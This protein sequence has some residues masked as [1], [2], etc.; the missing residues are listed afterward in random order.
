MKSVTICAAAW[1]AIEAAATRA[2]PRE[3]G[4][5]LLGY[6][7]GDEACVVRCVEV[8]DP[9]ASSVRYRRDADGGTAALK[10]AMA[11]HPD[12]STGY[13]GEWHSHPAASGP[14]TTDCKAVRQLASDGNHDV[15]LIVAVNTASGWC[16]HAI[17]ATPAGDV[18]PLTLRLVDQRTEDRLE[19]EH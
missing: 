15:L 13:V 3:T 2:L 11:S 7:V 9:D 12:G 8:R 18:Q 1:E 17:N 10:K 4:G 16:G 19:Y 14:S 6:Y 5:L